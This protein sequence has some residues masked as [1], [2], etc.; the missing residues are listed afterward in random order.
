[1]F[2]F[3]V[4]ILVFKGPFGGHLDWSVIA[5]IAIFL[6]LG[7]TI[8]VEGIGRSE[9]TSWRFP[10]GS[11]DLLLDLFVFW[12]K[13]FDPWAAQPGVSWRCWSWARHGLDGGE[14]RSIRA[15]RL[16]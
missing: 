3:V 13:T 14:D 9:T 10:A 7:V 11:S 8:L 12:P 5:T 4:G 2:S 1:V 16:S 6:T 15:D